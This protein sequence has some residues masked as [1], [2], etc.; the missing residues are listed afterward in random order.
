MESIGKAKGKH[1]E[2]MGKARGKHP[3]FQES[4]CPGTHSR[5][6]FE[7]KHRNRA[8]LYKI[9][10]EHT[11]HACVLKVKQRNRVK[12]YNIKRKHTGRVSMENR[13]WGN[14]VREHPNDC[15]DSRNT[16]SRVLPAPVLE[17]F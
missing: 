14:K 15:A 11:T 5:L 8:N 2:S 13:A 12:L 3:L 9:K 4:G 1:M 7:V 16:F 17:I 6:R 10:R